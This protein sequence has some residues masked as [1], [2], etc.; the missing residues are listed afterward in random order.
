MQ[1]A[2]PASSSIGKGTSLGQVAGLK[3]PSLS[4]LYATTLHAHGPFDDG[5]FQS[6][7]SLLLTGNTLPLDCFNLTSC[8]GTNFGAHGSTD[9]GANYQFRNPNVALSMLQFALVA[10]LLRALKFAT[11]KQSTHTPATQRTHSPPKNEVPPA[12]PIPVYK[13]LPSITAAAATVARA[14]R[15]GKT[16]FPAHWT[17]L[18]TRRIAL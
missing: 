18:C 14:S 17:V 9:S 12:M 13:V 6:D 10:N 5:S 11:K 4:T 7:H 8:S 1:T 2:G 16:D 15:L 3:S